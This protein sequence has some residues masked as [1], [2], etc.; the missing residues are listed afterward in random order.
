MNRQRNQI[1]MNKNSQKLIQNI[2]RLE[3][4]DA[5]FDAI[6]EKTTQFMWQTNEG[7]EKKVTFSW[8]YCPEDE[9]FFIETANDTDQHRYW[10]SKDE[11]SFRYFTEVANKMV[12][13]WVIHNSWFYPQGYRET[14]EESELQ[15]NALIGA[16][17]HQM[18]KDGKIKVTG[19]LN[20][21]PK[22][23]ELFKST[24]DLVYVILTRWIFNPKYPSEVRCVE[25]M[26]QIDFV[27]GEA[28][29]SGSNRDRCFSKVEF[30][31]EFKA[32]YQEQDQFYSQEFEGR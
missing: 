7:R 32:D 14:I 15:E 5:G 22:H 24:S 23:R 11:E 17:L 6:C 8:S 3:G 25:E 4:L 1:I 13:E 29:R 28:K 19:K 27:N 16:V 21:D 12:G 2:K 30:V 18:L 10:H 26:F 20:F 31:K 9:E